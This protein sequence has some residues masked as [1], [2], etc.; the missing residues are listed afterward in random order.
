MTSENVVILAGR[1][2]LSIIRDEGLSSDRV[3]VVAGAAGGPK[4]LVLHHLD[5]QLFGRWFSR[6]TRPLHLVGSSIGSWRFSAAAQTNPVPAMDR[7]LT[8]YLNQRYSDSPTTDEVS[9]EMLKILDGYLDDDGAL[10]LL[11]HPVYRLNVLAVRCRR[12]VTSEAGVLLG[13][14]LAGAALANAASRRLLRLFFE[15][16]LLY[17]SRQPP[18]FYNM[19][20]F[21]IHR[22][23]LSEHNLRQGLMASG[24]IPLVMAG[25]RD[26]P[27]APPGMYR[28]GGLIDY[29]PDL[30]Y[31][32]GGDELVLFPHYTDRIIPGWL[33]KRLPWRKPDRTNMDRVV[34]VAPS[35]SLL[36]GLPMGKIA[37]RNDF[38]RFKGDDAGRLKY[39]GAVVEA[40]RKMADS[41]MELVESG[42]IRDH[43]RP[44]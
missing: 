43:V 31:L 17:D 42:R 38:Y 20:G 39:W 16:I 5:R 4:W 18:P 8:A 22:T 1:R 28:D 13:L 7:F 19:D 35:R 9:G 33:D 12:S 30:P 25:V 40:G 24:S 26:I 3:A 37:D 44:L 29:H 14:G 41:F 11:N 6:R 23:A 15:R 2:A 10:G 21:P 36:A 34:L 32:D 27:G